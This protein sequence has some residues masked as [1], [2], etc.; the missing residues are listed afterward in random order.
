MKSVE[1]KEKKNKDKQSAVFTRETLG[2]ILILFCTLCLVCLIS[3]G[4]IFYAPGI[5]VNSFLFGTFG[6][7]AYAVII[8]G[9]ILGVLMVIGKK[10]PL[11][12]KSKALI[13]CTFAALVLLLHVISLPRNG[14]SYGAY[15]ERAYLSASN[16]VV[17]STAGGII[18]AIVA[19]PCLLILSEIGCYVV[20]SIALATSIFFVVK[21]LG[22]LSAK[23]LK[24]D[25]EGK[26]FKSSYV[27][28]N[29]TESAIPEGIEIVG[30]KDYPDLEYVDTPVS[31]QSSNQKLFVNNA[32]DFAFKTK[33][34]MNKN[35]DAPIKITENGGLALGTVY[36]S[37]EVEK[38]EYQ[39]KIEY[40]KKPATIDINLNKYEVNGQTKVSDYISK[41]TSSEISQPGGYISPNLSAVPVNPIKPIEPPV[42]PAPIETHSEN[43]RIDIPMYEHEQEKKTETQSRAQDYAEK[44]IDIPDVPVEERVEPREVFR[45]VE[46]V[47]PIERTFERD[48][49]STLEQEIKENAEVD[50]IDGTD[51]INKEIENSETYGVE[52]ISEIQPEDNNLTQVEPSKVVNDRSVRGIL[53]GKTEQVENKAQ[54]TTSEKVDNQAE[55]T[56][57]NGS[58]GERN[59]GFGSRP[60]FNSRVDADSNGMGRV[61]NS[62][63]ANEK[64]EDVKMPE[65]P[66]A[67]I[68]WKYK[69]PPLDLLERRTVSASS[70]G[71]DHEEKME[72]I[73][74]TLEEFKISA[75]PKNYVQGP[76]V[77]RYE[78]MM[79]SGV[80]VKRVLMY[81]DDLKMR[82]SSNFGVRIQAPIPGKNLV[83][84]EVANNNRVPVGLRE[85]LEEYIG[86]PQKAS[87]LTFAIGKDIV[88]NIITDNL[89][90]GPHFLV[91]GA[92]GSGKSVAL[93]VMIISLI[94]RYSPEDLRLILVDPKRV[95]FRM[96][97]HLPHLMIDEIVT[98]PERAVSILN[99]ACDEMERRY[100]VFESCSENVVS[101][102]EGY[103]ERIAGK[104]VPKMPRIVV[105][106]DEL[107]DLMEFC[108]KDMD[109]CVKRLT[110]KARAAGIHLVLATQ[111]PSVDVITGTI[112]ANLPSRMALKVLNFA[113]SSTILGEGGAEKLLGNG[114]MLYR[115]MGMSGYMR[116][117]GAWISDSEIFN[118][119]KYVKENNQ[120]YFD[121]ELKD[122]LDNANKHNQDDGSGESGGFG[123]GSDESDPL[124]LRALWFAVNNGTVSISMLQRRYKIGFNRGG[125]IVDTMERLGYIST[126]EGAKARKVLLSRA[127]FEQIYGPMG[128]AY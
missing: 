46:P 27:K 49:N 89:V 11:K 60:A 75:E 100:K 38:Q 79:P 69:R 12:L 108:K 102:I 25:K 32:E 109:A 71:E 85:V 127:E 91:A 115:N 51:V 98:E 66:K 33:R 64:V 93:N 39:K 96:Y 57:F 40:I 62:S 124:F 45:P 16:G 126:N 23:T 83:G 29:Q 110:A 70:V 56:L 47:K 123:D 5:W 3:R 104:T 92:T 67:P 10:I 65:K 106:V 72:I 80:S 81:D 125:A 128:E 31:S 7:F 48:R 42:S 118:I 107:A 101:D 14:M 103:N 87:E 97:E 18:T 9:I 63:S 68:D 2:V 55:N 99:W 76:A 50:D 36:N 43:R 58:V 28:K 61:F 59:V 1:R 24:A 52:D 19:Y 78:I 88:G 34:E 15:L 6:Y 120:T 114:D 37:A 111:R 17:G 94:M 105:V 41:D 74:R 90:K 117:Q 86:S 30:E 116:Y 54:E 121:E 44:Y 84:I 53:F 8:G 82:L 35:N 113:D 73:K 122:Y 4:A 77:T 22:L 95:G 112:K 20:F 119:V 21:S 13:T 26:G